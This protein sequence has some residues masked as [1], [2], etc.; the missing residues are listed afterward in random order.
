MR[1]RVAIF[2]TLIVFLLGVAAVL[3]ANREEGPAYNGRPLS[4]WV[5]LA[6]PED[7]DAEAVLK[8]LDPKDMQ[9]LVR[10]IRYDPPAWRITLWR[11]VVNLRPHIIFEP[12]ATWIGR[13]QRED[14][15][16]G[17]LATFELLG[18]NAASA[19]PHLMT[20]MKNAT[21]TP[22]NWERE[23]G[24]SPLLVSM[25]SLGSWRSPET[26]PIQLGSLPA[27]RPFR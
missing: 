21:A 18:T 13:R 3:L 5:L 16:R 26:P 4:H 15:A 9:Y 22:D 24:H 14:L 17:A 6:G 1:G 10:W 27:T 8:N 23:A 11:R 2:A 25:P 12:L 19:I 7:R 20:L